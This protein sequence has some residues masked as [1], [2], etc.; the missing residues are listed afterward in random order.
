MVRKRKERLLEGDSRKAGPQ[1]PRAAGTEPL[2]GTAPLLP[3]NS[4]KIKKTQQGREGQR[5]AEAAGRAAPGKDRRTPVQEPW[6]SHLQGRAVKERSGVLPGLALQVGGS[7][8]AGSS[9]VLLAFLP[10][11]SASNL[12]L[13]SIF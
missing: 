2:P 9:S 6:E 5:E 1:G 8:E 3:L 11:P 7:Q 12:G 13:G 10:K 4:P